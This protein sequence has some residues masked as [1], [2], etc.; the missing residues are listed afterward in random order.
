MRTEQFNILLNELLEKANVD[1]KGVM[2]MRHRP[3]EPELRRVLPSLAA[4]KPDIFNAWQQTQRLPA[5][6]ALAKA[7][8]VASFIGHEPKAAVFVGLYKVGKSRPLTHG[9]YW[10]IP[11]NIALK[12]FGMVGFTGDRQSVL[13]F[14]LDLLEAMKSW[15]GKLIVERPGLERSWWRWA[16]R[17]EIPVRAI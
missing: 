4:D 12:T 6:R 9:Q 16:D 17:N 7:S 3:Q 11:E 8:H 10:K 14:Q 13:W 5:E 15:Q 2:V 1:P